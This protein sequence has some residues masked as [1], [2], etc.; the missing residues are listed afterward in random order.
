MEKNFHSTKLSIKIWSMVLCQTCFCFLEIKRIIRRFNS[1]LSLAGIW[2]WILSTSSIIYILSSASCILIKGF[3]LSKKRVSFHSLNAI[4]KKSFT[5]WHL[6]LWMMV[7]RCGIR[8]FWMEDNS[9]MVN[10][11]YIVLR[12]EMK[13]FHL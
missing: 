8:L 2:I 7:Y 5:H 3:P 9:S 13:I 6:S 11:L 10:F 4:L 1:D 12:N